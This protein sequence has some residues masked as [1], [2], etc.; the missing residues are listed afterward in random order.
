M[1]I[2]IIIPGTANFY[3][4]GCIRDT[5]LAR[6]LRKVG[7]DVVLQPLYLPLCTDEPDIE[8]DAPIFFGG[9]NVYLQQKVRL[10]RNTPR[11][12]DKLFDSRWLLN[13]AAKKAGMTDASE[14]G[15]MTVSMLAGEEGRQVKELHRFIAWMR[16]QEKP[17][18]VLLSNGLL[19][20]MAKAI[21]QDLGIP[22]VCSLQGEDGFLDDLPE[23]FSKDA[24][25]LMVENAR[26]IDMFL[27]VSHYYAGVM[28]ERMNLRPEQCVPVQNGI[29]LDGYGDLNPIPETPVLGFLAHLFA[30][31]GLDHLVDAFIRL[32]KQSEFNSLRLKIAGTMTNA[33]EPF[34]EAMKKQL[35]EAG[36]LESVSFHPNITRKEK[37]ELLKSLSVLSVPAAHEE[38]FGL[39]VIEAMA[40]GVPVV[41]PRSGGFP[42]IIERTGGGIL[43][44]PDD[45]DAYDSALT[46]LLLQPEKAREMGVRG[47]ESV[48]QYFTIERMTQEILPILERVRESKSTQ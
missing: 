12:I 13:L 43:Y 8:N 20:G 11:W 21:S 23:P 30:A 16:H 28:K 6:A 29:S 42:E 7:H 10:F 34:V 4:G 48:F 22:V 24:W 31:K 46:E 33:D 45:L 40:A 37:I 36:V 26:Y 1:R 25:R 27:P 35:D 17:D 5:A 15:D 38:A 14:L 19:S 3:C 44:E 32:K 18:V 41:Q 39:Y 9:I 2:L 47:R